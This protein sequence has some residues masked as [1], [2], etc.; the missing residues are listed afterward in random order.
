[1]TKSIDT[2]VDDIYALFSGHEC[3][4]ERV[5]E[6]G[7]QL[8]KT[9]AARLAS[10][11]SER[12]PT[13]RMSNLG[14][15]DRQLWYDL[16]DPATEELEP[17][18]KIKFL[19]G[20]ILEA[21]LLFLAKEAGHEVTHEQEE[22]VL[23][24]IVGH[25]DAVID[26]VVVDCKSASTYAFAKFKNGTLA[27][28][29]PFGYMEQL[30]GYSRGLGGLDGAFLAIDKTLGHLTLL[31]VPKEELEALNINNRIADLKEV[32]GSPEP[33]ERCHDPVP[34]GES[35]NLVLGVNCS[36]CAHKFKC[37]ADANNGIGLRTFI[38][39]KGPKHFVQVERTPRGPIEV[40]F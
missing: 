26:G 14:K 33:P 38:Y 39:S 1:M 3:D 19:Y 36:Y 12:K 16:N 40:T 27:E 13:L 32:V 18:T 11:G 37:W 29:D 20:D 28:D 9:V 17:H 10:Y 21:L 23:D 24:D 15:G 8:S 6:F 31:K 35:G 7:E 22:L 34:D 2:L 4:P 30:A 25:N 5:R